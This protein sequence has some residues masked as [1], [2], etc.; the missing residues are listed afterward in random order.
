[1]NIEEN[2]YV[3]AAYDKELVKE[4]QAKYNDAVKET[5][6][7]KKKEKLQ[8]LYHEYKD[9]TDTEFVRTVLGQCANELNASKADIL[10]V[11]KITV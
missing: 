11:I 2:K 10:D 6:E 7:A 4:F 3:F 9:K 5:D 1:M 8:A